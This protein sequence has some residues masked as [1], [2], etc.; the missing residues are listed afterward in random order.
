[1]SSGGNLS[2]GGSQ[3]YD[4]NVT[5]T[6]TAGFAGKSADFQKG[7]TGNNNSLTLDFTEQSTLD[8]LD[9][10]RRLHVIW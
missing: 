1:M 8:G 2:D 3:F 7:V 10:V 6:G 9:N 5:L 4:G